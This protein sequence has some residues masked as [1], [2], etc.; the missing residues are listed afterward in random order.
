MEA[1]MR[2]RSVTIRLSCWN[3][4]RVAVIPHYGPRL[5]PALFKILF[6]GLDVYEVL[7]Y[8]DHPVAT[9]CRSASHLAPRDSYLSKPGLQSLEYRLNLTRCSSSA[10]GFRRNG[11]IHRSASRASKLVRLRLDAGWSLRQPGF[12]PR[13]ALAEAA[14][15]L[16]LQDWEDCFGFPA[17]LPSIL[18]H[19]GVNL[20]EGFLGRA[21]RMGT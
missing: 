7:A 13:P 12:R 14:S 21:S 18:A 20:I 11:A 19:A 9:V 10:A 16:C 4:D 17:S 15:D 1:G 5:V 8:I 3:G 2:A 6:K